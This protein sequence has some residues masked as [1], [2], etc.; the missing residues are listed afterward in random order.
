MTDADPFRFAEWRS[1]LALMPNTESR[2]R[3]FCEQAFDLAQQAT[4]G[5]LGKAQVVDELQD[6]ASVFLDG[7]DQ[8]EIQKIMSEAFARAEHEH[9]TNGKGQEKPQEKPADGLGE[10][11]AGD[12]IEPPP[13]R[14]WLLGVI[15]CRKFLSQLLGE[16]GAGKTALRILQLLSLAIGRSLTGEYV[17]Q[18]CRVLIISLEDDI[19]ELRR[20]ILAVGAA[21]AIAQQSWRIDC[22][23]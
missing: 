18:R 8:D 12:D 22:V 16:G 10:W 11:D 19:D 20:R 6:S 4:V 5:R 2:L 21:S 3:T 1:M 13:P 17:F 9:T 15:F 23:S 7:V 14:G